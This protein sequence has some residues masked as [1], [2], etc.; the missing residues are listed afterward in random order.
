VEPDGTGGVAGRS[1]RSWRP[2]SSGLQGPTGPQGPAG[3]DSTATVAGAINPDGTSQV[4]TSKFTSTHVGTGHYRLDFPAGVFSFYPAATIMPIGKQMYISGV[5][6][7]NM[8]NGAW[9]IEYYT[10][11]HDTLQLE[12]VLNTFIATPFSN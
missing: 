10:A 2:R 3:N 11:N 12:D 9:R 1:R 8:G 7:Y 6:S 5:F 4:G